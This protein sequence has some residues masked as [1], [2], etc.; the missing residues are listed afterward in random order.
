MAEVLIIGAAIIDILVYPASE[1]VFHTGSYAAEDIRMSF[2]ADAL[3]EAV[4]LAGLGDRVLLETVIGCDKAG[5]YILAQCREKGIAIRKGCVRTAVKTGINV[6]LVSEN[7]ERSFLTNKNGSLRSLM[8]SDIKLPFPEE[9]RLLCFASIFVFPHIGA[10]ELEALFS[11]AKLQGITVC[12]DMTKCKNG[13]TAETYARAFQYVD[14]LFA[15]DEEARLLTE[16]E[17]V[18]EA[19]ARL[20][21]AGAKHVIIKCGAE[22]CYVYAKEKAF[23]S[24]ALRGVRCVDTTGAGDSFAAG[25]IHA[26][27][28]GDSLEGCAEYANRCGGRAAEAIGATE[29]LDL[30][31]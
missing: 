31:H 10:G 26:L 16:E 5:E 19:A 30:P 6:V 17:N 9:I 13:E 23:W 2:G 1:R 24:C 22:G 21:C 15:N 27:L 8:L 25:F 4:V 20:Y 7:G 18:E 14:Y 29:W 28:K 3:N 11:Q 12:A